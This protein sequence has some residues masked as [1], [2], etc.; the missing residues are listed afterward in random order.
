[1]PLP[2][3][4]F[5]PHNDGCLRQRDWGC[6]R[7]EPVVL[8]CYRVAPHGAE[9]TFVVQATSTRKPCYWLSVR[10]SLPFSEGRTE[11]CV[12]RPDWGG[13]NKA[14]WGD[15]PYFT[16]DT[17]RSLPNIMQGAFNYSQHKCVPFPEHVTTHAHTHGHART[18]VCARAHR[19]VL[20]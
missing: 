9:L 8:G 2:D 6:L 11:E 16:R 4:L 1:M 10:S 3:H 14:G 18:Q 7:G 13:A 19:R 20:H 5:T 17:N 15:S 12:L